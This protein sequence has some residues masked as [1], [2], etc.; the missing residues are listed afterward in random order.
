MLFDEGRAIHHKVP[1]ISHP[2]TASCITQNAFPKYSINIIF[3]FVPAYFDSE[4]IHGT[5]AFCEKPYC[6]T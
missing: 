2:D 3:A 6:A 1:D 4:E 5:T